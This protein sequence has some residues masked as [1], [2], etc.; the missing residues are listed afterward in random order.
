METIVVVGDTH[1]EIDRINRCVEDARNDGH[2]V[3]GAIQVGDFGFYDQ[4]P[5]W[6]KYKNGIDSFLVPTIACH[7]NHED[8][9]EVYD[10]SKMQ[11]NNFQ[12]FPP[13]AISDFLGLRVL[14]VGG[15]LSVDPMG[16]RTHVAHSNEIY[17]K[18][19][20]VWNVMDKPKIDII[21]THE[22]PSNSGMIPN[23]RITEKYGASSD[24][25]APELRALIEAVQPQVQVNG[26]HHV[27]NNCQIGDSD[28]WCLPIPYCTHGLWNLSSKSGF[29]LIHKDENGK[30]KFE[31]VRRE[32]TN[33]PYGEGK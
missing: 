25:G 29:G 23:Q 21:I 1:G 7:G 30:L 2:N 22:A 20:E 27:W 17:T 33:A 11:I 24:L 12:L 14:S 15:A 4:L 6:R 8:P 10:V 9:Y 19:L 26:H 13:I 18:A 31:D 32:Y 3:V 16:P 28:C 5:Q